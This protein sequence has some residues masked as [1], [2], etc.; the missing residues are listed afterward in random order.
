MANTRVLDVDEN[1]IRTRLLYGD[2]L[3][4]DGATSLL[5][6]LRPLLGRNRTHVDDD[7]RLF[8]SM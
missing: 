8:R 4:V 2:L 7:V 5:D 3:V 1:L 6:D